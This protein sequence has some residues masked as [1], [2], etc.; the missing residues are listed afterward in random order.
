MVDLVGLRYVA[1]RLVPT[2]ERPMMGRQLLVTTTGETT[3][4][5]DR[6]ELGAITERLDG[7]LVIV[8]G[9]T[10]RGVVLYL[11]AGEEFDVEP[12][13]AGIRAALAVQP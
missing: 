12:H 7:H 6:F 1:G 13:A 5:I 10:C 11:P 3:C 4:Q 2:S 9:A 8:S